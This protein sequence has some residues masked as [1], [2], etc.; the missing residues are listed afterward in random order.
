MHKSLDGD[1]FAIARGLARVVSNV[2]LATDAGGTYTV[3]D[4]PT[5]PGNT[6]FLVDVF[7]VEELVH[8]LGQILLHPFI[9]DDIVP[10]GPLD[11]LIQ[12]ATRHP[13][14]V[15]D[16]D[17]LIV[18]LLP[19]TDCVDQLVGY[20][21]PGHGRLSRPGL[22][23]DVLQLVEA[24]GDDVHDK[25]LSSPLVDILGEAAALEELVGD[26]LTVI[27]HVKKAYPLDGLVFDIEF[28]RGVAR[29]GKS[30]KAHCSLISGHSRR[31]RDVFAVR[32]VASDRHGQIQLGILLAESFLQCGVHIRIL[33]AAYSLIIVEE[34][35]VAR[36]GHQ[37][38]SFRVRH[39][40]L[41]W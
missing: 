22:F 6:K 3:K 19:S 8:Q 29:I 37:R 21:I 32:T 12:A 18:R 11:L 15:V 38:E 13:I 17:E 25:V 41:V 4:D 36:G 26:A 33:P 14:A 1:C 20:G 16:I 23:Q 27:A 7:T 9:E 2:C 35:V 28:R 5:F 31:E 24:D 10:P 30:E 40:S 39:L 34:L